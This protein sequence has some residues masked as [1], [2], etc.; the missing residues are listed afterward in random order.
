MGNEVAYFS[1]GRN[2][3][4]DLCKPLSADE[5][6]GIEDSAVNAIAGFIKTSRLE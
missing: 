4:P 3:R 2:P 5:F 6:F 1:G